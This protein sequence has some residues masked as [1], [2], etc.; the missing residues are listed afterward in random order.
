LFR[1][2]HNPDTLELGIDSNVGEQARGILV[3]VEKRA[4]PPIEDATALLAEF[5]ELSKRHEDWL[6]LI[7]C[8][9]S[10]VLHG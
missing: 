10:G 7:Q 5:W 4:G 3:E 1:G 6:Q 9:R 8:R 2:V